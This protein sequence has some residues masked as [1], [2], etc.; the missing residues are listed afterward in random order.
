P[1]GDRQVEA[2]AGPT[3]SEVVIAL[4]ADSSFT[5]S[6]S[7]SPSTVRRI[8]IARWPRPTVRLRR[9]APDTE[10]GRER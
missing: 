2:A 9:R 6:C 4:T 3:L 10:T 1:R 8:P 5:V 7:H